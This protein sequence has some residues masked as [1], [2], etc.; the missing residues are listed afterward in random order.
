MCFIDSSVN[1]DIDPSQIT[2]VQYVC[3]E[4]GNKFKGL[5]KNISCSACGSS[6][7]EKT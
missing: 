3:R 1:V 2:G 5:G 4:C 7:V 6:D